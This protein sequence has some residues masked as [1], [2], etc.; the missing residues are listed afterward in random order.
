VTAQPVVVRRSSGEAERAT[1]TPAAGH[2]RM[3]VA[4]LTSSRYEY[5]LWEMTRR[6]ETWPV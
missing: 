5:L 1:T 4:L 3:E 6:L 2:R